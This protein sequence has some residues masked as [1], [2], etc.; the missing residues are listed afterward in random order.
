MGWTYQ[1]A[2]VFCNSL[3]E[4]H[5]ICLTCPFP[6]AVWSKVAS[7][8]SFESLQYVLYASSG[9]IT[10]WWGMALS[11]TECS[12]ILCGTLETVQPQNLVKKHSIVTQVAVGTWSNSEG[13]L[14]PAISSVWGFSLASTLPHPWLICRPVDYLVVLCPSWA[15]MPLYT[16][17]FSPLDWKTK[18]L[19]LCSRINL[20][21][22]LLQL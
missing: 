11:S 22:P 21:F 12:S 5:H 3:L 4:G 20:A 17:P 2:C 8:E 15:S 14:E 1:D 16:K 7:W 13:L 10:N 18:V 9:S 19:P 6:Q